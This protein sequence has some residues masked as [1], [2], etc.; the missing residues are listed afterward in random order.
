MRPNRYPYSRQKNSA[1]S[2]V[3]YEV[4][5]KSVELNKELIR[6]RLSLLQRPGNL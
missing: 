6:E 5:Q 2:K 3:E 1:L 4:I